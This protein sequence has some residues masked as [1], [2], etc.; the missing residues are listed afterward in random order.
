MAVKHKYT[1]A[2]HALTFAAMALSGLALLIKGRN[3]FEV[4]FGGKGNAETTHKTAAWVYLLTNTYLSLKILPEMGIKGNLTLK[5]LFQR[6]FYWFVFLSLTIMVP[7]GLVLIFR[8]QM[9]SELTLFTLSIHKTFA[10]ILISATLIHAVL[11]F[12][13]PRILFEKYKEIC[14][15]C[16]EKLCISVCPT[17]A[18]VVTEDGSINFNDVRCI[19]CNKCVEVCPHKLVYYSDRGVPLYIK[20]V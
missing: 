8:H 7:T 15:K 19:A 16:A 18:I 17:E 13:K 20:P 12:H 4:I 6:G 3:I 1:H 11:R 2:I 9:P 14:R 5:A 10:L